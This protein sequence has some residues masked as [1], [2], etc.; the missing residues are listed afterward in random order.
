MSA[1]LACQVHDRRWWFVTARKVNHSAFNGYHATPS[2]YSEVMC[3]H[4][5]PVH[6]KDGSRDG[7]FWRTKAGY[8]DALPDQR[9]WAP[10]HW[11]KVP[12]IAGGHDDVYQ[13]QDPTCGAIVREERRAGHD[14]AF[15][16][17]RST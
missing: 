8:V 10:P 14:H 1:G 15:H 5:D 9:A 6:R 17:E 13:C 3:G 16:P 12:P 4:P 2:A 7:S 11:A